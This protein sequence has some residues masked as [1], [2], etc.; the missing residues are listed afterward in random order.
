MKLE[1]IERAIR[2]SWAADTCYPVQKKEWNKRKPERGQCAVTALILH[3]FFGGEIVFNKRRDHFWNILPDGQEVDLTRKQF[4]EPVRLK[5]DAHCNREE[6]LYSSTA[7]RQKTAKRY[8]LLL[9]RVQ[10]NLEQVYTV[11]SF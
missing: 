6:L 11:N 9:H 8:Q 4:N 10:A 5:V 7:V 1:S 3:E 2:K